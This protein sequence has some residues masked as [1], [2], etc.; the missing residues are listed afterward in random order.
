MDIFTHTMTVKYIFAANIMISLQTS[1]FFTQKKAKKISF[2][3][4]YQKIY[5]LL[6]LN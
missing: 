2:S 1:I 3:L 4:L 5:V 6:P